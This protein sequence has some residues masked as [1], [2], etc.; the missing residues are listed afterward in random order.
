MEAKDHHYLIMKVRNE[1]L[2]ES[3]V[4]RIVVPNTKTKISGEFFVTP[5]NNHG[6]IMIQFVRDFSAKHSIGIG[7]FFLQFKHNNTFGIIPK[8]IA[9]FLKVPY[10]NESAGH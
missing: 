8:N 1:K 3:E 7:F 6:L 5:G 9:V 2:F 10:S 4:F